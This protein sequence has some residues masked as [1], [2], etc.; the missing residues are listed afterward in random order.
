[1]TGPGHIVL[2]GLM[3]AGK[4]TIGRRL[5]AALGRPFLDNDDMLVRRTGQTARDIASR[6]GIAQLHRAESDV[7]V[8]A[9]HDTTPSVIAA[10]AAAVLAPDAASALAGSTVVYL[11]VPPAE[12]E[13]RVRVMHDSYRPHLDVGSQFAERDPRYRALASIVV[14]EMSSSVEEIVQ[15]IMRA[16]PR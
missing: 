4:S 2:V 11:C 12:L 3:G 1:M 9:V 6:E 10:S 15:R 7:L 13:R 14:D 8:E 5:A 16:L